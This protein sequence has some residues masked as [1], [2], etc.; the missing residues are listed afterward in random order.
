M[1]NFRTIP[2]FQTVYYFLT[3]IWPLIH[4]ES[5]LFVSGPK[6]DIWLVKTVGLLLLPYS[7]LL[8]YLTISVRKNKIIALSILICCL[9]L[10]IIDLYYYIQKV[11]KWVYLVDCFLQA[12]F[13]AYWLYYLCINSNKKHL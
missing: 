8:A 10:L 1:Q 4:L 13:S 12:I 2:F 11:I 9:S 5:F 3:G 6:T 7:L